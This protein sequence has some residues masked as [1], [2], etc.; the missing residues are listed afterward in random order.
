[1]KKPGCSFSSPG[2]T[3]RH[4]ESHIGFD[5]M[6]VIG[7]VSVEI[8]ALPIVRY[9]KSGTAGFSPASRHRQR[10]RNVAPD[11]SERRV[12]R[13]QAEFETVY[14]DEC[15]RRR[16]PRNPT[17]APAPSTFR[18]ATGHNSATDFPWRAIITSSPS[19]ARSISRESEFIA[20]AA[21]YSA[22]GN[23]PN[24]LAIDTHNC[25][26]S[27]PARAMWVPWLFLQCLPSPAI[28]ARS[29]R[30]QSKSAG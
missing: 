15:A 25:R 3:S 9:G 26:L 23:S 11:R 10:C 6:V 16:K 4:A 18:R 27:K 29:W 7:H 2:A 13:T 19:R 20:S 1:M 24:I 14:I 12:R 5:Q 30:Q 17:G 21:P 8:R 22:S 28:S